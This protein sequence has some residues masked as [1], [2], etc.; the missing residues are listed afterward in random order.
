MCPV[1][2]GKCYF[3]TVQMKVV[4]GHSLGHTVCRAKAALSL[5]SVTMQAVAWFSGH[6]SLGLIPRSNIVQRIHLWLHPPLGAHDFMDEEKRE[7][8]TASSQAS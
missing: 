1:P 2:R 7:A 5:C 8:W 3:P 6:C 4:R